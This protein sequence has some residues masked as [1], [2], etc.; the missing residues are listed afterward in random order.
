MYYE[1]PADPRRAKPLL[2]RF[3]QENIGASGNSLA[4]RRRP[5][6]VRSII[7]TAPVAGQIV[8]AWT[9]PQN[10]AGVLGF[11]VYQDNENN[12][13][14]NI[15]D[16]Q[17]LKATINQ[18]AAGKVAFFVSSYNAFSESIKTQAVATVS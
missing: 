9:G 18:L 11:N 7:V 2:Q 10:M 14:L 1:L 6:P 13:I 5:Q 3:L 17:T 4:G 12:R 8:L 16:A 15:A